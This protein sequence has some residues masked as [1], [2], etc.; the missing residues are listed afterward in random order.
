VSADASAEAARIVWSC[1]G[2]EGR[3]AT[4]Q[5]R[6]EDTDWHSISTAFA[7]GQGYV[8]LVDGDVAGGTSYGYRIGDTGDEGDGFH[9]EAW[10]TIPEATGFALSGLQPNP[11]QSQITVSFSL[12]DDTP[13]QLV[14]LD[15]SGRRVLERSVG[16]LGSGYHVVRFNDAPRLPAGVYFV[17]L[18]QGENTL[19]KRGAIVR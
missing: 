2:L 18:T 19:V 12:L 8:T 6:T 4:I 5:R 3:P 1:S 14:L 13:A 17:R 10:V 9:G 16:S 15:V 11:A 7:D